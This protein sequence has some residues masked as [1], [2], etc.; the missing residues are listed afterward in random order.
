MPAISE[1]DLEKDF[2]VPGRPSVL[3]CPFARPHNPSSHAASIWSRYNKE[4][5]CGD[6]QMRRGSLWRGS[7]VDKEFSTEEYADKEGEANEDP[8]ATATAALC[9]MRFLDQ[10]SPEEV[11]SYFERHKHELPQ[12]H[13]ACVKRYRVDDPRVKELDEKYG[14][15]VSMIKGL[16]EKHQDLLIN[17]D[18]HQD[19]KRW[20]ESVPLEEELKCPVSRVTQKGRN[21]AKG[22][23]A[24]YPVSGMSPHRDDRNG[25]QETNEKKFPMRKTRSREAGNT[26]QEGDTTLR[27]I[28]V[29]ESPTRPWGISVPVEY[30]DGVGGVD[31]GNG[32]GNGK[33]LVFTGPVFIGYSPDDAIR[34]LREGR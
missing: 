15:L 1:S 21:E 23:E 2:T 24:K 7:L 22:D 25:K 31:E 12:S 14:N 27:E 30:L 34:V 29:G 18:G 13:T 26:T 17:G 10:H 28:R 8:T 33:K 20:A 9:P 5:A 19:I 32:N 3:G 4:A 6:A 11:A 16:G